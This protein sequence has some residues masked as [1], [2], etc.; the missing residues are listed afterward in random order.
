MRPVSQQSPHKTAR[1]GVSSTYTN[2]TQPTEVTADWAGSYYTNP[3][4]PGG[5]HRGFLILLSR[6]ANWKAPAQEEQ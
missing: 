6:T 5:N 1:A 4:S 2:L 3:L